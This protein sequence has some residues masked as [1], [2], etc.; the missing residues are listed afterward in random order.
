MRILFILFFLGYVKTA[1]CVPQYTLADLI[2]IARKENPILDVL[3]A[4]EDAAK[5]NVVT[6]ES[7]LNPIIEL[8][9]GP[10]REIAPNYR[11]N[12]RLNY[13]VNI[14]QP[15][16]FQ[17]VRGAK[18]AVAESRVT[19]A[20]LVT[21]ATIINLSLQIK[22]AF[23]NVLQNEMILKI[24][25]GDRDTLKNIREKIALR[26]KVGEAPR[27]ELIKADTELIA[28]QRD[29]DA[30]LLRISESKL[31]LRGMVSKSLTDSF[32]LTGSLPPN[33]INLNADLLKNDIAKSPKLKQ[34]KASADIAEKRLRL[35]EKLIIP[36]LTLNAG[37]DQYPDM[38]SYRFGIS[39][40]IPIWNQRQGQIGEA[41][42]G[43]RE[44][45][46]QYKDQELA[47]RRD[48]ESAFQRYLIA[49]QQVKTFESTLLSQA[50]AVLK[51]AE[52]AYRY[53][54][55]GILEYLDA[56]RTFRLVRKDYLASK[57]D[58]IIAILE[59]EQLLGTDILESKI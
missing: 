13:G 9:T 51:V 32:N 29:A 56:Q 18:K 26:V 16:E 2:D 23:Y 15:L 52:S 57:Y 39:A 3:E 45:Q 48:I 1:W 22:K 41:A 12:Q 47:L 24:A 40:P 30:A 44:L 35:E 6:A 49:Q 31:H 8:G 33:D 59:I 7:Y 10:A 46:A 54:E 37:F 20:S 4:K 36:G 17:N 27:Y 14:S 55:R 21:E 28:A 34:I 19:Y 25:E 58:Y 43:Y 42:A 53:G 50:E 11:A 38:V 5:Y